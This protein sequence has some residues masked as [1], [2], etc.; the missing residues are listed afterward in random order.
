MTLPKKA[1]KPYHW[2]EQAVVISAM[3]RSFRRYPPFKEV[4]D[5]CK[6]EWF[7][8]CK[9]GN[10]KR[11]VNFKC[12]TCNKEVSAKAFFVDHTAPVVDVIEGFKDYNTYALRLF[13]PINNLTGMC[14]TCHD[15]KT[16]AENKQRR[17]NKKG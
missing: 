6:V 12:E 5:R 16:K 14:K 7:Q 11:R 3:R 9:N 13:C 17:Q 1:K 8:P 10:Q 2:V 15:L 4:R